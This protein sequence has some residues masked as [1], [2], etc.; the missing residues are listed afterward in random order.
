MEQSEEQVADLALVEGLVKAVD[1]AAGM[2]GAT[3]TPCASWRR[4]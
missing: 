1:K 4:G 2:E 3:R